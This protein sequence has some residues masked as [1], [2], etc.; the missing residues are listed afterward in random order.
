MTRL[1]LTTSDSGGGCLKA[2]GIADIVIPFDVRFVWGPLPS[3]AELAYLLAAP[4][5]ERLAVSQW[6]DCLSQRHR[7]EIEP[8]GIGLID[9]C[10]QCDTVELWIDPAPKAQLM[11]IW[12]LACFRPHGEAAS[13]LKLRQFDVEIGGQRPESVSKSAPVA[14][15]ITDDHLETAT[16]AWQAYRAPTPEAWFNLL[17]R[18]L[19]VLPQ[20]RSTIL[21]L[22]EEL[23]MRA[24]G[25]SAT[26]MRLLEL[27]SDGCTQP[28]D[29]FPGHRKRNTR[30]VFGYWEVGA[31]LDGLARAP[32]PAISGLEEGP[33]TLELHN[34][35]IRHE[36]YQQS[37]LSLTPLGEA[38]LAQADDFSQHNP[39]HRWWGGIE[40]TNANLWRWDAANSAL[41]AP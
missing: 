17:D 33:F 3:D 31:L 1:I 35:A 10:A 36:R 26:E 18:D 27:I 2:A 7:E 30:R 16:L 13:K 29:L 9:F 37:R 41:L 21:A 11:M 19:S 22:L 39:I 4:S 32:T 8:R 15:A 5:G 6:L 40:L 24:T 25:L 23:P 34:D 14:V 28:G 20:L 38:I 12:L